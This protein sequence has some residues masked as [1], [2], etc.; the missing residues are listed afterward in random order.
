MYKFLS[1][2]LSKTFKV[3][4]SLMVP[5]NAELPFFSLFL[6]A[7]AFQPLWFL[8]S[9][10]INGN[11]GTVWSK[12]LFENFPRA[13]GIAYLFTLLVYFTRIKSIRIICYAFA[14]ILLA[15][16]L[17]LQCVFGKTLQPA[18]IMLIAETNGKESSEFFSTFF[19]SEGGIITLT[20]VMIYILSIFFFEKRK[21]QIKLRGGERRCA[22]VFLRFARIGSVS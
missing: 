20:C 12:F 13:M 11:V 15:T 4:K 8:M 18:I 17:F 21:S 14:T 16:C 19:F 7:I 2:K 1:R 22:S 9:I 10:L 6:L 5:V 3:V